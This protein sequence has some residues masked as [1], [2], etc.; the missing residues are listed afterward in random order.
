MNIEAASEK[1][2]LRLNGPYDMA[3]T[4]DRNRAR[5]HVILRM[6]RERG[7]LCAAHYA[8]KTV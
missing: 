5:W 8:T 2:L 6:L 3:N 4:I 1:E 7:R